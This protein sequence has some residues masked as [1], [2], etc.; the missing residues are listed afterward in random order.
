MKT[1]FEAISKVVG[2]HDFINA[3]VEIDKALKNIHDISVGLTQYSGYLRYFHGHLK[4]QLSVMT[5]FT[6]KN[7]SR[8]YIDEVLPNDGGIP[9][10]EINSIPP[11]DLRL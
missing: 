5:Q 4:K 1:K 6:L 2:D 3:L 8:K 7:V 11:G 10:S 9:I